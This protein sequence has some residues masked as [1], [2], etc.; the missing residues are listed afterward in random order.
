MLCPKKL[1][2]KKYH[3]KRIKTNSLRGSKIAFG[4]FALI[5][6]SGGLISA[7]QIESARIAINK[8]IKKTG[9]MWIRIFPHHPVTKKP[10]E[11]RMGKGKG[12]PEY[13]VAV[14]KPGHVLFE[15]SGVPEE[16][17]KEALRL[18]AHKLPIKSKFIKKEIWD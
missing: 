16:T 12:Q 10:A 9:K 1:K 14:V 11:T 5:A 15:L 13:W 4:S 6:I 3:K 18:A 8:H 7:K 2:Y 17:A